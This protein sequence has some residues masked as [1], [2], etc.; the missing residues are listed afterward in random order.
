MEAGPACV[1]RLRANSC[2]PELA[3]ALLRGFLGRWRWCYNRRRRHMGSSATAGQRPGKG[4]LGARRPRRPFAMYQPQ[5]VR[6]VLCTFS[7]KYPTLASSFSTSNPGT[8]EPKNVR[9]GPAGRTRSNVHLCL[10]SLVCIVE[11]AVSIT[12]PAGHKSFG[13]P[14]EP[15]ADGLEHMPSRTDTVGTERDADLA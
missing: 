11:R 9:C 5:L 2:P 1:Q 10:Q 12:L 15:A 3:V 14:A 6:H 8:Q 4:Y 7:N 13:R